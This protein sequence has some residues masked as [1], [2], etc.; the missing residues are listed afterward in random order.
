MQ[1]IKKACDGK[2]VGSVVQ[3]KAGEQTLTKDTLVI[4]F[5]P[6]LRSK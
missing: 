2:A 6:K 3:I 5:K 1:D 4:S